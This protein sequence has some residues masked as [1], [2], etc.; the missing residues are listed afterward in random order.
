MPEPTGLP[1]KHS[2]RSFFTPF[3]DPTPS[4]LDPPERGGLDYLPAA[5]GPPLRW[6][7][8]GLNQTPPRRCPAMPGNVRKCPGFCKARPTGPLIYKLL[9]NNTLRLNRPMSDVGH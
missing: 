6:I 8:S 2:A 7:S 5:Q 3:R 9:T 4:I 1:I